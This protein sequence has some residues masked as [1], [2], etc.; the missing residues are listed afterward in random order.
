MI[1]LGTCIALICALLASV[2]V[3]AQ[4][5]SSP[6]PDSTSPQQSQ[7]QQ[8]LP[9]APPPLRVRP[10]KLVLP[11]YPPPVRAVKA[12]HGM[13]VTPEPRAARIGLE[14]LQRGGNAV[15]AAVAV[16]FALAVTYPIAGNI[17]GGG[18]MVIH[19]AKGKRNIAIDYREVSPAATQRD[20]YLD[21]KG[22]ADP[23]KSRESG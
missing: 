16:G 12:R 17:G 10:E 4:Q 2:Q 18:F 6:P 7:P 20:T 3:C 5:P 11:P 9:P 22:N 23:N 1:R 13:V 14:V 15:D 19:L 21:D 8:P